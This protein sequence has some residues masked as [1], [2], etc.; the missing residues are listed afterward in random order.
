M[1]ILIVSGSL[2]KSSM[3]TQLAHE[4]AALLKDKAEVT[5]LDF[6]SV[7][8]F[9]QDLEFP[10]QPAVQA[11][12]NAFTAA[13]GIWFFTPEYNQQIPGP[14]KNL[15]DW[16]SRPMREGAKYNETAL[17]GRKA[18][19]SGIGGNGKTAG[20]RALLEKLLS[21]CGMKVLPD[22]QGFAMT[23]QEMQSSRL[24][25]TPEMKASLQEE[26]DKFLRFIQE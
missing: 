12:R 8:V 4:A 17:W 11:A 5:F 14:L 6:S 24:I 3:N 22:S 25:V 20:S 23:M 10:V 1:N 19:I 9:N 18:A 2:R 7:P 26:A 16:M 15:L 13:D 21:F